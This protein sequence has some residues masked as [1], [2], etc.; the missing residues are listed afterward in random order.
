DQFRP[1]VYAASPTMVANTLARLYVGQIQNKQPTGIPLN[2]RPTPAGVL[3]E[4]LG[5][6]VGTPQG[7]AGLVPFVP[8][9]LALAAQ[10]LAVDY[11]KRE[12]AT[13]P[14]QLFRGILES[15]ESFLKTLDREVRT[16]F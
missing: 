3:F 9:D 5:L 13:L 16:R 4:L 14:E 11:A 6:I 10:Q 15:E 2:L 8:L 12:F 7:Q 1:G